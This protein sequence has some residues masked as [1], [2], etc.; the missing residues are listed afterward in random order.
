MKLATEVVGSR[1]EIRKEEVGIWDGNAYKYR[2]RNEFW[3]IFDGGNYTSNGGGGVSELFGGIFSI[4][5]LVEL[6]DKALSA[7]HEAE[8]V[9]Y[10]G[11]G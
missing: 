11:M 4:K 9:H 3:P 6:G 8:V 5:H 2:F 10:V 1:S 7:D